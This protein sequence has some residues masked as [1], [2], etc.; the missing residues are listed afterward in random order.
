MAMKDKT[1]LKL[2]YPDAFVPSDNKNWIKKV[3]NYLNSRMGKAGVP[4]SYVICAPDV[5]PNDAPD[6]Y[7]RAL[8]AASFETRQYQDDSRE[9][10][11]LLKDLFTK[12]AKRRKCK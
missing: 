3:T 9:I 7:T 4:L 5:N 10:Y 1:D 11:H 6:E 8:W 12:T 2:Y